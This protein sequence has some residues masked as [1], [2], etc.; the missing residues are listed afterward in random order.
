M[1]GFGFFWVK[2]EKKTKKT[3]QRNNLKFGSS[4]A[5]EGKGN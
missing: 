1:D 3:E 2:E 4:P 5:T